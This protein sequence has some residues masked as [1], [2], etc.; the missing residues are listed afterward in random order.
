MPLKLTAAHAV[1]YDRRVTER[2]SHR[3]S[4]EGVEREL[5]LFSVA[6]D[7]RIAVFNLLGDTE[8][9]VA[10]ARGLAHWLE[11]L[12]GDAIVT[13]EPKSVPLVYELAKQ[14]GVPWVVLR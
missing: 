4:I 5:P 8:L 12:D 14:L 9:W 13:A 3:V 10:A 7:L 1:N 2:Q 6:P 11:G